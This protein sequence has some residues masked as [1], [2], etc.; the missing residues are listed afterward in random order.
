MNLRKFWYFH[1]RNG[2]VRKGEYGG[3]KWEFRRFWLTIETVSGNFKCRFMAG[4]HPYAYLLAGKDDENIKGFC[5][6]IYEMGMLLTTDQGFVDD[7]EK[8]LVKYSKRISKSVAKEAKKED[9]L[10]EKAAIEFEKE[11]QAYKETPKRYRR[12]KDR[13]IEEK[14]AQN[15][16]TE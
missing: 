5:Q 3:F 16:H 14:L 6:M 1:V 2:V 10:D 8:A 9:E 13:E 15:S 11:V 4:E 7:I 12:R